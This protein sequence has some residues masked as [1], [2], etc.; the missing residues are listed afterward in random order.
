MS[1]TQLMSMVLKGVILCSLLAIFY[2]SYYLVFLSTEPS[3]N[4][5]ESLLPDEVLQVGQPPASLRPDERILWHLFNSNRLA[6]LQQSILLFQQQYP[7]WKPPE[8]LLVLLQLRQAQQDNLKLT[9]QMQAA[10]SPVV[11]GTEVEMLIQYILSQPTHNCTQIYLWDAQ[12]ILHKIRRQQDR[13]KLFRIATRH[14]GVERERYALLQTAQNYLQVNYFNQLLKEVRPLFSA[15]SERQKLTELQYRHNR[16]YLSQAITAEKADQIAVLLALLRADIIQRQAFAIANQ[17]AWYYFKHNQL[18]SAIN[19]F[20]QVQQW[21]PSDLDSALGLVQALQKN[22]QF[23][24][25]LLVAEPFLEHQKMR[26][27]LGSLLL[28]QGQQAYAKSSYSDSLLYLKKAR[29]LYSDVRAV[30]E[31]R[32]WVLFKMGYTEQ[33]LQIAECYQQQSIAMQKLAMQINL[34]RG[35]EYLKQKNYQQAWGVLARAESLLG[36]SKESAELRAWLSYHQRVFQYDYT[37]LF[38]RKEFL[39]AVQHYQQE[40]PAV[41]RIKPDIHKLHNIDSGFL[42]AGLLYRARTGAAGTSRLTILSAPVVGGRFIF[43]GGHEVGLHFLR[44]DLLSGQITQACCALV[45]SATG[46]IFNAYTN[47]VSNGLSLQ[48]NYH[49]SGWFSPYFSIG[50]TPSAGVLAPRVKWRAGFTQQWQN[51]FW[52]LEGFSQP[53]RDSILSYTGMQDPYSDKKWGRVSRVGGQLTNLYQFNGNWSMYTKFSG[54]FVYGKQVAD[55]MRLSTDISIAYNFDI[56]GFDYFSIGPALAVQHYAKNLRYFTLGHGGYFS[57][58]LQYQVGAALQFLTDEGK[59]FIAKGRLGIGFQQFIEQ[60]SLYFPDDAS[61]QVLNNGIYAGSNQ[62]ALAFEA[63]LKGA[64]L[65]HPNV[66]FAGG[67][68]Y[69]NTNAYQDYFVGLNLRY[70]FKERKATFSRDLPAFIFEQLF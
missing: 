23:T 32:A 1:A 17:L 9:Q 27:L 10:L 60:K 25:A 30:D 58:Q 63:E 22:Q 31:L 42:E 61:L 11:L 20:R 50:S 54:A 56:N 14:C 53:V 49:K 40:H 46:G 66:Q 18:L 59:S 13:L 37:E 57:P 6:K 43:A 39:S 3:S 8:Q 35:W 4:L 65:V 69:R 70:Y 36:V 45:G 68:G 52:G 5:A 48:L 15:S 51:G 12:G 24:Q 41:E 34:Q 21:Q 64:W 47:K 26:H 62:K 7:G 2:L 28:A 29:P 16:Y 19:W 55:N 38:Y 67:I 44:T 33:A